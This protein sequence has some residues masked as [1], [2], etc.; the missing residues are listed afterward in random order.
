VQNPEAH[1]KLTLERFFRS[2]NAMLFF[3]RTEIKGWEPE[4]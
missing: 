4:E 2:V 1:I 3:L